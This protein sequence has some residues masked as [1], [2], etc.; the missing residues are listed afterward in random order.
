MSAVDEALERIAVM[1]FD[2]VC[3]CCAS[4]SKTIDETGLCRTCRRPEE[5]AEPTGKE[6]SNG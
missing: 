6:P 2:D 1:E 3:A 5:D 4:E